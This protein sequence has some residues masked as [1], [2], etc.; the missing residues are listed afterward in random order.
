MRILFLAFLACLSGSAAADWVAVATNKKM[1]TYADP[2]TIKADGSISKMW[3]LYDWTPPKVNAQGVSHSSTKALVEY[4]CAEER[5]RYV[6]SANFVDPM[7]RGNANLIDDKP[8][9]WQPVIPGSVALKL[10]NT[11]CKR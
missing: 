3:S 4:D 5:H 2:S 10:Y 7:G 8:T 6:Y 9:S 1:T 11:A